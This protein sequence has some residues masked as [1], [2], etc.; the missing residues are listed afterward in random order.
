M[1]SGHRHVLSYRLS[2]FWSL[3]L[4]TDTALSIGNIGEQGR[5]I[6]THDH[7]ISSQAYTIQCLD[8]MC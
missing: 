6:K 4:I 3:S 8:E 5:Q 1:H 7:F 2:S